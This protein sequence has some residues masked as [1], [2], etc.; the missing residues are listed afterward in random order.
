[1]KIAEHHRKKGDFQQ[2]TLRQQVLV[3][4]GVAVG[5]ACGLGPVLVGFVSI[6]LKPMA[7]SFNWSR[8]DVAALPSLALV[9]VAIGAPL[10]GYIADR[11]GWKKVMAFT[12]TFLSLGLLALSVAPPSHAYIVVV[13]LFMGIF[14]AATMPSGWVSVISLN[15]DR[16]LGMALG[17]AMIGVGAGTAAMPVISG[18][19]LAIMDWR[20]AYA[21]VA[22][23]CLLLG[24]FAHQL[25]FRSLGAG[26][27]RSDPDG[28]LSRN[29]STDAGLPGEGLSLAEAIRGYRFWVLGFVASVV[30]CTTMGAVLHLASYATDRGISPA[31]AAQSV[32]WFGLA[33]ALT[34]FGVGLILDKVFAPFVACSVF[35]IGATGLYL[36]TANIVQTD[37]ILPLAAVLI[38]IA[39]GAEGDVVPYLTRKYFGVRALGSLYGLFFS[40]ITLGGAFGAYAYGLAFDLLKS[41]TPIHQASAALCCISALAILTLGRYQFSTDGSKP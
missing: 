26:R 22:G 39:T 21:S 40:F 34:R 30:Y 17:L 7:A 20:Q 32:G 13:A 10:L 38:G 33:M 5:L 27:I 11:K 12:V 4:F 14:G 29:D 41:Y 6:G 9:G 3:V 1:M 35:L 2:L 15:F 23:I 18:K 25:T 19:L 24:L 8:A 16:R 31:V 28:E 37:W 36:L